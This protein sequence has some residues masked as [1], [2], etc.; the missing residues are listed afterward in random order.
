MSQHTYNANFVHCVFST[1]NR[2]DLIPA[3]LLESL[4]A[5]F[6]GIS[7]HLKIKTLAIGGTENHI[8]LLLGLPP[9]ITVA[10]AVQ[11]LKAN[12]SRWLGEHG[13]DFQ[14]QQGYG[15]FSVSPSS[16]A[17]V[18]KYIRNQKEHHRRRSFEEEFRAMLDKS[19][20]AYETEKLF[21]A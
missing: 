6:V 13:I 12:S 21:A 10:E 1:K 4:C 16:V 2:K 19:G 9:T 7:N 14:W 5:Y 15:A 20:I 11:K 3:E 17:V 8:H 18:Q